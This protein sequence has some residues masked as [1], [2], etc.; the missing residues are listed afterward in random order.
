MALNI[1]ADLKLQITTKPGTF[2]RI[3]RAALHKKLNHAAMMAQVEAIQFMQKKVRAQIK[4]DT[5]YLSLI[6]SNPKGLKAHF[7]LPDPEHRLDQIIE[8]F[9]G[10]FHVSK[11]KGFFGSRVGGISGIKSSFTMMFMPPSGW[12]TLTGLAAANLHTEKGVVLPWLEWLLERG[13]DRTLVVGYE[14]EALEGKYRNWKSR[15][16]LAVMVEKK[17]GRWGGRWGVPLKYA[18]TTKKNFLTRSV[19][20]ALADNKAT[21][22]HI[23]KTTFI[24][25]LK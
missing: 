20:T 6:S 10:S 14:I 15:T 2:T 1:K 19:G 17:T 7:G 22:A 11:R 18:G 3:I 12:S 4:L 13:D 24:R 8:S 23:M 16:G 9:V 21:L 25:N 5:T